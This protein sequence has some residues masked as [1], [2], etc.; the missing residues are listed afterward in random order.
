VGSVASRVRG[1]AATMIVDNYAGHHTT[2]Y[3]P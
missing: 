3:L 1:S 2:T